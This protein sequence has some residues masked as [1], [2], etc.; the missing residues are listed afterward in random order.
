MENSTLNLLLKNTAE[1][2]LLAGVSS[3]PGITAAVTIGYGMLNYIIDS[4][5]SDLSMNDM[6]N[7]FDLHVVE[8]EEFVSDSWLYGIE[9]EKTNSVFPSSETQ[10]KVNEFNNQ[11][12]SIKEEYIDGGKPIPLNDVMIE[13]LSEYDEKNEYFTLEKDDSGNV[14][15]TDIQNISVYDVMNCPNKSN[16]LYYVV[17]L[18]EN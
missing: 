4:A 10:V 1:T 16:E 3:N 17:N 12:D 7:S 6:V 15:I 11:I 9:T 8:T 18:L 14:Y 5:P 13:H 2:A